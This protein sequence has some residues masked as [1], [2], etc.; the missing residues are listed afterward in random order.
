MCSH[1]V[2][3]HE[4][5]DAAVRLGALGSTK[6]RIDKTCS[7]RFFSAGFVKGRLLRAAEEKSV[8]I[9]VRKT[10][11]VLWGEAQHHHAAWTWESEASDTQ[12][13]VFI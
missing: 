8:V 6:L 13:V 5:K 11:L 12:Q 10:G 4:V 7:C 2:R 1:H 3:R 9:R